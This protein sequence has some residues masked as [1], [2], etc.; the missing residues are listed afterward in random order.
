MSTGDT[1]AVINWAGNMV[2]EQRSRKGGVQHAQRQSCACLGL[3]TIDPLKRLGLGGAGRGQALRSDGGAVSHRGGRHC[4][5]GGGRGLELIVPINQAWQ[6]E[7]YATAGGPCPAPNLACQPVQ[8]GG[9]RHARHA[10]PLQLVAWRGA[11][12]MVVGVP[13]TV[14][15][16]S[17]SAR[18]GCTLA[19]WMCSCRAWE[20]WA[21]S[22]FGHGVGALAAGG[23]CTWTVAAGG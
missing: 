8:P 19:T 9:R 10:S 15:P 5:R 6:I 14:S 18:L 21:R 1:S 17:A 3:A 13:P 7:P 20:S 16:L 4:S 12:S 2:H 22:R 11:Q 23:L